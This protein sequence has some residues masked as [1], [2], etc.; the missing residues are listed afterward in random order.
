[1]AIARLYYVRNA[2]TTEQLLFTDNADRP[3]GLPAA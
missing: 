3:R 1:M 2:V